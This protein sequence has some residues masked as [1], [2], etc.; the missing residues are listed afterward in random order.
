MATSYYD[1]AKRDSL[2]AQGWK[3]H[4]TNSLYLINPQGENVR[5][6]PSSGQTVQKRAAANLAAGLPATGSSQYL[7]QPG[8]LGSVQNPAPATPSG[9]I[10][11]IPGQSIYET[12][13]PEALK[14][15]GYAAQPG[16]SNL[17][18]GETV[19]IDQETVDAGQDPFNLE[20]L[21]TTQLQGILD[22]VSQ[23]QTIKTGNALLDSFFNS[24][25]QTNKLFQDYLD[26]QKQI[27]GR[28]ASFEQ[29][30]FDINQQTIPETL[31]VGQG[32]ALEQ[33]RQLEIGNLERN[34]A[35][36]QQAYE[37]AAKQPT[38]LDLAERFA[39]LQY[40]QKATEQLGRQDLPATIREYEYA[41][42]QGFTGTFQDWQKLEATQFGTEGGLTSTTSSK[43]PSKVYQFETREQIDAL[44]VSDLTKSIIGG[45]G[46]VKSLTP[47]DR[48]KVQS[49]LYAI[50][51]NPYEQINRKLDGLVNDWISV[52]EKAK[53]VFQG[54]LP[55]VTSVSP[56]AAKFESNKQLL[57]R[58][59]ARLRDVGV[60][61]D[62]DV[63]SYRDALPSRSDRNIDVVRAKIQGV[64]NA[65][66]G[67][68]VGSGS[69]DPLGIR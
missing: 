45:Y 6:M 33:Q 10:V 28:Q 59:I 65:L 3:P 13:T 57:T 5:V 9:G 47:T 26:T 18:V 53:G 41:K 69:S 23:G 62:Q 36:Q 25:A 21:N 42:N 16:A 61:S 8:A 15:A 22:Q 12:N 2:L 40:R 4:P 37:F 1:P 27:A 34:A 63:A 43:R 56:T 31:L 38:A 17:T 44:P 48:A 51:F 32:R 30:A 66:G 52:D 11:N 64:K 49:E 7:N 24:Q 55:F 39:D 67:G 19:D 50:G 14:A 29:G 58:E 20:S 54:R 68:L 60:L 35:L 46:D